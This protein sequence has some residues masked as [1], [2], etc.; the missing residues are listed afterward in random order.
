MWVNSGCKGSFVTFSPGTCSPSSVKRQP[1]RKSVPAVVLR[2]QYGLLTF[3]EHVPV[4][5]SEADKILQALE[6]SD[7]QCPVCYAVLVLI[8]H[9]FGRGRPTP[10]TCIADIKVIPVLL[11][12]KLCARLFRYEVPE[13]RLLSVELAVFVCIIGYAAA[14]VL[15]HTCQPKATKHDAQKGNG[16]RNV[17]YRHYA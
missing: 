13:L 1:E 14:L 17:T 16:K 9:A 6:L 10:W 12:W 7:N 5:T 8:S 11:W 15:H 4:H 2:T 3:F